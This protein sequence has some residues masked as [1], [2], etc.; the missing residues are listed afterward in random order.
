M[1]KWFNLTIWYFFRWV[2]QPPT[3][4]DGTNPANH[5]RLVVYST[6]FKVSYI[7]SGWDWDIWTINSRNIPEPAKVLGQRLGEAG[8]EK[9]GRGGKLVSTE[10]ICWF[11]SFFWG[12]LMKSCD[13]LVQHN[14]IC[15]GGSWMFFFGVFR[16]QEF[17]FRVLCE[18]RMLQFGGHTGRM[19]SD[20][21]LHLFNREWTWQTSFCAL[22]CNLWDIYCLNSNGFGILSNVLTTIPRC[23]QGE[24]FSLTPATAPGN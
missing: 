1:G 22:L 3:T 17:G 16:P 20:K 11:D 23:F 5:L 8:G 7:P 12:W 2:V 9:L 13:F 19:L 24:S 6:F 18:D 15:L 4:V 14:C 10:S 21:I